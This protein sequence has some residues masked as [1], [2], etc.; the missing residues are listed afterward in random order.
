MELQEERNEDDLLPSEGDISDLT[1]V[2][3]LL[4]DDKQKL[5]M[6]KDFT[7]YIQTNIYHKFKTIEN[8]PK[9]K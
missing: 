8:L 7:N 3:A 2:T 4:M 1:S 6:K 5:E 9:I